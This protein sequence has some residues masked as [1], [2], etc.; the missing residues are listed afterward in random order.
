MCLEVV[1][2][3]DGSSTEALLRQ[4]E[5]YG[6]IVTDTQIFRRDEGGLRYQIALKLKN[7]SSGAV[8]QKCIAEHGDTVSVR[9]VQDIS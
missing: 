4:L 1:T 6:A 9:M 5:N 3:G 7:N 2:S 8:L